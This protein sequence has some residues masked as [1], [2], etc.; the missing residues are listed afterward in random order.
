MIHWHVVRTKPQLEVRASLQCGNLGFPVYIPM[1]ERRRYHFQE[2]KISNGPRF[3]TYIFAQFDREGPNWPCLFQRP[4]QRM[5]VAGILCDTAGRPSTVPDEAIEAMRA[6]KPPA[7]D[8][9]KEEY[10]F[11]AGENVTINL[12]GRKVSGVFIAYEKKRARVR[13]WILGAE[14]ISTFFRDALI[15]E[16]AT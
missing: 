3:P 11:A 16:V 4:A 7:I 1:I 5:G 10:I 13:T 12:H 2:W 9:I 15:P 8:D 6:F 14:R